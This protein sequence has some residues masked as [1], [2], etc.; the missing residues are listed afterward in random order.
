LR[1]QTGEKKGGLCQNHGQRRSK[2]VKGRKYLFVYQ[3]IW[4]ARWALPVL[5]PQKMMD[6]VRVRSWSRKRLDGDIYILT[7]RP[8]PCAPCPLLKF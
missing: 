4:W 8:L 3:A 7:Q 6:G 2:G 5:V 1:K